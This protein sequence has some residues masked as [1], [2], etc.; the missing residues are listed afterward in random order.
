MTQD[1]DFRINGRP[2]NIVK[3]ELLTTVDTGCDGFTVTLP[4][5]LD[6][7]IE[8]YSDAMPKSYAGVQIYLKKEL[9]LTGKKTKTDTSSSSNGIVYD[10][11]GFSNT[12]NFVDSNLKPPYE[13]NGMKLDA[14]TREVAKQ[15]STGVKV[16]D[17]DLGD[18]FDRATISPGQSG[19]A[20]VAPLAKQRDHVVSSDP[21]GNI[22]LQQADAKSASVGSIE[23]GNQANLNSREF[24]A[25]FDDRKAFRSYTVRSQTPF[26]RGEGTAIDRSCPEPRHKVVNAENMIPGGIQEVA[27]WQRHLATIDDFKLELPVYGWTAP[28]GDLWRHNTIVTLISR[29]LFIPDG[30]DL[31]IRAVRYFFSSDGLTAVLSLIPPNV[32]TKEPVILPWIEPTATEKAD[33]FLSSFSDALTGR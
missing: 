11:H 29:S 31:Y 5:N 2:E 17:G 32:Y 33:D 12:Y 25:S 14:I 20:F 15:T 30:F 3:G 26:G 21:N 10:L 16:G 22:L 23:E 27:E 7:Q 13:L 6:E 1:F 8:L 9:F 19:F 28:N 4:I 18:I 24:Q